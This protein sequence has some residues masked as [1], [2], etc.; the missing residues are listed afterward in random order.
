MEIVLVWLLFAVGVGFLADSRGRSGFGFFL[1]SAVL[2]PILGLIIVLVIRN[3]KD[4]EKKEALRR[5]EHE[6]N[7]ESIRAIA[8]PK[9]PEVSAAA[10]SAP[11]Q[12]AGSSIADEIKKLGELR[13]RGFLTDDEFQT[14][15]A[16]LLAP[17]TSTP[18]GN[19]ASQAAVISATPPPQAATQAM[20]LCPNCNSTI[21]LASE[22]CPKCQASLAR[23]AWRI[24]PLDANRSTEA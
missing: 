13:E 19:V 18:P 2:S 6:R 7:L 22:E 12:P 17:A 9:S 23:S 24:K 20:G 4:E 10:R 16:L 11:P 3:P 21:P 8:A 14:Q 1:V 15:K 5:E